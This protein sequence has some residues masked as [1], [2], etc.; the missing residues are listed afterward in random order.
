MA[1]VAPRIQKCVR[2]QRPSPP[3]R[4]RPA[5]ESQQPTFSAS[6]RW[7]RLCLLRRYCGGSVCLHPFQPMALQQGH[8]R[9]AAS[10]FGSCCV[11]VAATPASS[12]VVFSGWLLTHTPSQGAPPAAVLCA[13][14]P[15][16]ATTALHGGTVCLCLIILHKFTS[17]P[18][19]NNGK[20]THNT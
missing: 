15:S 1:R 2:W 16:L 10:A 18:C 17:L 9:A 4:Q 19:T 13:P 5:V 8:A 7:L 3:P 11:I 20:G 14:P 12:A 6:R